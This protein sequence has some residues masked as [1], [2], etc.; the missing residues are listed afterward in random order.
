MIFLSYS[1][2]SNIYLYFLYISH[3]RWTFEKVCLKNYAYAFLYKV[4]ATNQQIISFFGFII[5]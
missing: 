4:F 5:H 2:H 3:I 1:H